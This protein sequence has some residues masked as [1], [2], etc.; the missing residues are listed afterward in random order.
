MSIIYTELYMNCSLQAVA[1]WI[2]HWQPP[3]RW[4]IRVRQPLGRARRPVQRHRPL[5]PIPSVRA[6]VLARVRTTAR[7]VH[8]VMR[9]SKDRVRFPAVPA[10]RPVHRRTKAHRLVRR[11]RNTPPPPRRA[12]PRLPV[13]DRRPI[14]PVFRHP[15]ITPDR[16]TTGPG[17]ARSVRPL[18]RRRNSSVDPALRDH[19]SY[20]R[21]P[22]IRTSPRTDNRLE[23]RNTAYHL[24]VHSDREVILWRDPWVRGIQR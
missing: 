9:A 13:P 21:V 8:P 15:R 7:A 11:R 16:R 24:E 17:P 6:V 14:P 23:D 12:A 20:H 3:P 5:R 2:R 1:A 4:R 22:V 19:R 10:V 18:A